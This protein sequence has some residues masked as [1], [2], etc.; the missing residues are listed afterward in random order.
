MAWGFT[1]PAGEAR[2]TVTS[3]ASV[4][5]D[6][7]FEAIAVLPHM[8]LIG[9]EI[10]VTAHLPDGT[11]RPLIY[12]DD[13]DFDWQLRYT[14]KRPVPL[15]GGTQ[16]EVECVYDN[17]SA[18]PRNPSAPPRDVRSG[19]ATTDEMCNASVLGTVSLPRRGHLPESWD[20]FRRPS[21][22]P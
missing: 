11:K 1:I 18:N 21:G 5:R 15:P 9:R 10:R 19:F 3:Y 16:I 7:H 22:G 20:L 6:D 8:H 4:A 17:S 12:I 2:H 13:W 14:F